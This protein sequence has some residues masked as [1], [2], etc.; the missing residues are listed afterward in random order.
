[1]TLAEVNRALT[2]MQAILSGALVVDSPEYYAG[3]QEAC[4]IAAETVRMQIPALAEFR[5][6]E[7]G[8]DRLCPV[9]GNSA[10]MGRWCPCCGQK[11]MMVYMED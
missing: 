1:M 3:L 10:G 2:D 8:I 9:C 11:L 7:Y 5:C 6:D 4:G